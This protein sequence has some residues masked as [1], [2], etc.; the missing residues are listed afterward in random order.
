MS[1]ENAATAALKR[2]A[3]KYP[4]YSGALVVAN[5]NMTYGKNPSMT[6]PVNI[7]NMFLSRLI[8]TGYT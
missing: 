2:I 3:S 7:D 1:P 4:D 8:Y 5:K 6:G